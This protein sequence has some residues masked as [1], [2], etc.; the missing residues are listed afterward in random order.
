MFRLDHK[1]A[2]V[3][4]STRG[5]GWGIAEALAAQGALVLINGRS[6]ADVDARVAELTGR[7]LAAQGCAFDVADLDAVVAAVDRIVAAHGRIDIVVNNAGIQ[8]RAALA[9]F[10]Q[11]EWDRVLAV[12]LDAPFAL[13]RAAAAHM[14]AEGWGRIINIGSAMGSI[15]RPTIP[16]YVASKSA[17]AGLTRALAVELAPFGVTANTIAPGYVATELNAALIADP[18]FDAMVVRRT[19]AA[20]WGRPDEIA[21]A[22]VFLASE[23]AAYVNGHVLV[24]DG[25]LT[26]SL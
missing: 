21:A 3:T 9:D 13:S 1:V 26:V 11:G 17:L 7:R 15:A 19:P 10:E 24:V 4:G 18:A 8:H 22:A 16:A 6:V 25:G 5:L 12:N 23:E 2:L 14:V 20:R